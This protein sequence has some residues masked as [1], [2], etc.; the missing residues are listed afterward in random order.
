MFFFAKFAEE[1]SLMERCDWSVGQ[2]LQIA[3]ETLTMLFT[4]RKYISNVKEAL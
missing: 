1:I 3:N 2:C 4:F